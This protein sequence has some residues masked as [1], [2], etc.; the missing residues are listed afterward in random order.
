LLAVRKV[1]V[2][3]PFEILMRSPE[4]MNAARGQVVSAA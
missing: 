1:P 2:F 3:G 4:L